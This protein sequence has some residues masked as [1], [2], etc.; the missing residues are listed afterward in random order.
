M[1]VCIKV[2][3]YVCMY[4]CYIYI[5]EGATQEF[6]SSHSSEVLNIYME[7]ERK[8]ERDREGEREREC[9]GC[10]KGVC[11][12]GVVYV[13]VGELYIWFSPCFFSLE[14]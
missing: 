11:V 13:C 1:Y 4:A 8:R 3:K 12:W 5:Y 2:S 14:N 6:P 9:V 7:N 10:E